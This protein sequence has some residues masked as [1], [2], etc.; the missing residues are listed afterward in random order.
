MQPPKFITQPSGRVPA[1][2]YRKDGTK[3]IFKDEEAL[4]AAIE[5]GGWYGHPRCEIRDL[6]AAQDTTSEDNSSEEDETQE[7]EPAEDEKVS[8]EVT[9]EK[10]ETPPK[11]PKLA[12]KPKAD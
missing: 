5:E 9:T 10:T 4:D 7:E 6:L 11:R 8:E 3:Q 2:I 12:L 1:V